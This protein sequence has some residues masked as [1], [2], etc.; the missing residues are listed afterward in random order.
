MFFGHKQV[1]LGDI[2]EYE[3][4][5]HGECGD[6]ADIDCLVDIIGIVEEPT[7]ELW[8][9]QQD[10]EGHTGCQEAIPAHGVHQNTSEGVIALM[11]VQACGEGR[12]I[13]LVSAGQP[14]HL[15]GEF[16]AD[17]VDGDGDE[18]AAGA[19]TAEC[20]NKEDRSAFPDHTAHRGDV[21]HSAKVKDLFIDLFIE[22]EDEAETGDGFAG[23]VGKEPLRKYL[24]EHDEDHQCDE[25]A[26]GK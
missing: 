16:N 21:D 7:D 8:C 4:E 9:A 3:P 12:D 25:F 6:T 15:H 5:P 14:R 1:F 17:L 26:T 24:E 20:A 10:T 18:S 11:G 13:F 23:V 19:A 22:G 2:I